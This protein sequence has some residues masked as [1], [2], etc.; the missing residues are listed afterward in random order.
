MQSQY[1]LSFEALGQG[2]G[3]ILYS[4]T[5]SNPNV[6]GKVLSIPGIRD[7]GYVQIGSVSTLRIIYGQ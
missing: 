6:Y 2:Y 3:F 4:T 5:L 1:P 7:R